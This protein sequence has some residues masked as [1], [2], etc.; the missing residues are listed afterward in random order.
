QVLAQVL[1]R[2]K[3][4][5]LLKPRKPSGIDAG[6]TERAGLGLSH[7]HATTLPLRAKTMTA[8]RAAGVTPR[9]RDA[10]ASVAGLAC[11]SLSIISLD[12]PGTWAKGKSPPNARASLARRSRSS[13][14]WRSR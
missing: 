2:Q 13:P 4:C 8:A 11:D 5:Q 3:H 14:S 9:T 7:N 10:A 6:G 1:F 12:N